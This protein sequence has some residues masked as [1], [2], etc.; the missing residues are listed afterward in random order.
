MSAYPCRKAAVPGIGVIFPL[1]DFKLKPFNLHGPV[2]D[3]HIRV[4]GRL[5]EIEAE[6]G[7]RHG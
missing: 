1:D 6:L 3:G 4:Y 5:A 2:G 7:I